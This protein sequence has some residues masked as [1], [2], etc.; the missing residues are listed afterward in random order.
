MKIAIIG[1]SIGQKAICEK[2][3]E[4]GL[5]TYCFAWEKGA[6][7]R[8]IV[9]HFYPIS[10]FEIEQIAKICIKEQI[11]GVVSNASEDTAEATS[12]IAELINKPGLPPKIVT[13]IKNKFFVR[14]VSKVIPD[15][16]PIKVWTYNEKD[17]PTHF[18]CIVKPNTGSSKQGVSLVRSKEE[19]LKA[20]EYAKE[21]NG[22]QIIIEEYFEGQEISV[23]A[24]S[25]QGRH[26]IYQIT[27]KENSGAPHFVELGHHEPSQL[28]NPILERIRK[29]I[30]SLLTTLNYTNG[31]S[32]TEMKINRNGEIALIEV[33]PRGGGDEISNTLVALS[34]GKDYLRGMIEVALGTFEK[35]YIIHRPQYAG[36]YFL[37]EQTRQM[38]DF[39]KN[40]DNQS[41][42]LEKRVDDSI[43]TNATGNYNRNGYLIYCADHKIDALENQGK[44]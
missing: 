17:L 24:L 39:F 38:L 40:A 9:D 36:I 8:N 25:F 32:H 43:L 12:K 3:K 31:A 44:T 2:A 10:I 14:G 1:A 4:M 6:I 18:P 23:E 30:P 29:I 15:L 13:S 26:Y 37:C 22:N 11:D 41:W 16:H 33:N 7:C 42:L 20:L 34:S 19:F 27:D 21:S 35:P 28:D 5:E